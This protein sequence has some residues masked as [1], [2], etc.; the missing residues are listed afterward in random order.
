MKKLTALVA[1]GT[2]FF[3]SLTLASE[4]NKHTVGIFLGETHIE[5]DNE[6]SYGAEYEYHFNALWGA[7][8]AYERVDDAH[9]GDGISVLIGSL[10]Y[11]PVHSLRLGVGFGREDVRDHHT[12][13]EDIVRLSAAYEFEVAGLGIGPSVAVDVLDGHTDEVF[14]IAISKSF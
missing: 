1:L 3:S 8:V 11:H 13:D 5:G 4:E 6:F 7:G 2:L 12:D 14:G 9:H 10:Y